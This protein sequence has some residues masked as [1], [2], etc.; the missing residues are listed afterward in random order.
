MMIK[1]SKTARGNKINSMEEGIRMIDSIIFFINYLFL[2]NKSI[3]EIDASS[4]EFTI[5]STF[6]IK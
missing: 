4:I 2:T 3:N 5:E 1:G 6:E